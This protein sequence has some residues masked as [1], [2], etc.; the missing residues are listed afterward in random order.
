MQGER[1]NVC[2]FNVEGLNED[3]APLQ[4]G[5]LIEASMSEA[6]SAFCGEIGSHE[7]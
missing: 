3:F 5:M 2:S 7:L 4:W 6:P 1:K